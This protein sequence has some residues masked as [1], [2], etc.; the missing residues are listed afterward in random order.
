ML[1][2]KVNLNDSTENDDFFWWLCNLLVR[3]LCLKWWH[4]SYKQHNILN[5]VFTSF[6]TFKTKSLC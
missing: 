4:Y 3:N 6:T 2:K 1:W 5:V